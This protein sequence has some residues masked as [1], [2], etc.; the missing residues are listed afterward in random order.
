MARSLRNRNAVHLLTRVLNSVSPCSVT[1]MRSLQTLAYE[2]VRAPPTDKPY[3]STAFVL[4]G[5]LGSGRNWRSF[6][7]TLA[8]V[9]VDLRNHGKSAELEG[10]DPPHDMYNAAKDLANLV[11]SRGW[12]WPDVVMGH[13]MG[14]KVALQFSESC[15]RGDYGESAALPKQL[16]V[17]D[18][19]PGEAKREGSDGEVEKVLETLQKLPSS[20]PSRKWLVNHMLELGF[21]KSLS[22]WIGSNLKRSG[23]QETWAFNLDGAVQMFNSYRETSYWSLLEKPPKGMEISV[24]RAE[25]S[26]RWDPETTQR[27]ESLSSRGEDESRGKFSLHLLP[28]SGHWVH[29]DNPKGLL[30]IVAPRIHSFS[31]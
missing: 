10:F 9:L 16:W 7:R 14:G 4:H 23:D 22:D 12:E 17:L 26:D 19:V 8:M 6:S 18:S 29:V 3:T 13:S 1:S 20:F 25:K 15:A 30:E 5:L 2:E 31:F 21:S 27:L 28:D 24:V 11:E